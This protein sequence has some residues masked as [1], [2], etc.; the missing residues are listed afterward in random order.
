M[1]QS[2][3]HHNHTKQHPLPPSQKHTALNRSKTGRARELRCGGCGRGK[4]LPATPLSLF[5]W[6]VRLLTQ[7][8]EASKHSRHIAVMI[9]CPTSG[10]SRVLESKVP[11]PTTHTTTH[12]CTAHCPA[13]QSP[14]H[15]QTHTWMPSP[16]HP[17]PPTP[18]SF[19]TPSPKRTNVKACVAKPS[20][21]GAEHV[22]A[23]T[24]SCK[25]STEPAKHPLTYPLLGTTHGTP[26]QIPFPHPPHQRSKENSTQC[27]TVSPIN[28]LV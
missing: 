7:A 18:L 25:G 26:A 5:S 16:P 8:A 15:P 20:V 6:Q 27:S 21:L 14:P 3:P 17:H 4:L 11:R 2:C 9:R 24:D 12:T 13:K 1:P 19:L 22:E 28:M 10:L 23:Q